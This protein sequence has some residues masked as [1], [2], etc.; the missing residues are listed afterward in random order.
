[1]DI[2]NSNFLFY[3]FTK[4]FLVKNA[5]NKKEKELSPSVDYCSEKLSISHSN[6]TTSA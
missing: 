1:M 3:Y 2:R 5:Q 6:I 4:S